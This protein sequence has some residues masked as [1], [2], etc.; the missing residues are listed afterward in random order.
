MDSVYQCCR[1]KAHFQMQHVSAFFS[2][3]N[4][5]SCLRIGDFSMSS[6]NVKKVWR[7][8]F[9]SLLVLQCSEIAV[10]SCFLCFSQI[11]SY[12][13][14]SFPFF[15]FFFV[16]VFPCILYQMPFWGQQFC[17]VSEDAM[18]GLG[19]IVPLGCWLST[20]NINLTEQDEA[21]FYGRSRSWHFRCFT[22]VR[23]AKQPRYLHF[24]NPWQYIVMCRILFY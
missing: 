6:A 1:N 5:C 21:Y 11:L 12:C 18:A 7:A 23:T 15:F 14:I 20:L 3:S 19:F 2:T 8:E 22:A 10:F 24:Y 13:R 9:I 4:Q 17:H 16:T